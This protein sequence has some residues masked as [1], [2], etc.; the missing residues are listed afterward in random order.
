M[1][2]SFI[3]GKLLFTLLSWMLFNNIGDH[4]VFFVE[5]AISPTKSIIFSISSFKKVT[6]IKSMSKKVAKLLGKTCPHQQQQTNNIT[7]S[8]CMFGNLLS[9]Y[10]RWMFLTKL[11]IILN[12]VTFKFYNLT[13]Y[14]KIC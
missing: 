9:T 14:F 8:S 12:R 1:M 3:F 4:T 2:S 11:G 13:F 7:M 10:I 5:I 6:K